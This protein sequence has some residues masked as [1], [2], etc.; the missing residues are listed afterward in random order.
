MSDPISNKEN[1][2][3]KGI[4]IDW[5]LQPRTSWAEGFARGIVVAVI[6]VGVGLAIIAVLTLIS[7][8]R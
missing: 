4:E 8:Y 7:P 6:T 3:D 1:T 2:E 5:K